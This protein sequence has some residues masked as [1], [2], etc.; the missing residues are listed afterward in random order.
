MNTPSFASHRLQPRRAG[1]SRR[2]LQRGVSLIEAL[3]AFGVMAFGMMAVV[4]MQ[5]TLRSSGDLARQ[6]AEA[7]RIA[8]DAVETWR[9][10]STL[11]ATTNRM[12]YADIVT[13]G[14][15][16]V[17]G[18]NPGDNT[19]YQLTRRVNAEPAVAGTLAAERLTLVVDVAWED[20]AGQAQSVRLASS[21][22]GIEPELSASL[23]LGANPDPVAAPR[24]RHR[25]IPPSAVPVGSGRSGFVP[26]GQT[27]TGPRVAWVFNNTTGVITLCST[28][29]VSTSDLLFSGNAPTCGTS[30]ALLLTGSVRYTGANINAAPQSVANPDGANFPDFGVQATQTLTD[31]SASIATCYLDAA[32]ADTQRSYYCAMRVLANDVRWTGELA[33]T[34]P[35]PISSASGSSS[36]EYRV[37]RYHAEASYTNVTASKLNQNYVIIKAGDGS[38]AYACPTTTTPR[39][40]AHQP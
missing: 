9:G 40:W 30:L 37:C 11:N 26:P 21:I 4:G 8:Q 18:S 20:R 32:V 33:F 25:S 10:F 16:A 5:A 36:A 19:T 22:A 23:M 12:A 17:G 29:G 3:V 38:S 7:V 6:R 31:G 15:I 14:P 35:L 24:G 39:T 13:D 2:F 27:G 1:G 34:A 28:N